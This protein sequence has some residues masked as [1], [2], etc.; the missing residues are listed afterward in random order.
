V[1]ETKV[2]LYQFVKEHLHFTER[3]FILYV[4]PPKQVIKCDRTNLREFA[5]ATL[6]NFGWEDL[7]VTNATDGPF[8]NEEGMKIC[9]HMD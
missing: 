3:K 7:K 8:V 6:L 2:N 5:P 9:I 1:R 4:T